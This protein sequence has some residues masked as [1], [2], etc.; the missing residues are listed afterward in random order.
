MERSEL[1]RS[2]RTI[3]ALLLALSWPATAAPGEPT[4][5]VRATPELA[6]LVREVEAEAPAAL[7]RAMRV[8]APGGAPA[9]P[10]FEATIVARASC[11]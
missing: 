7:A 5:Q 9:D 8:V 10:H 6:P 11:A 3:W 1:R 4:L 2:W